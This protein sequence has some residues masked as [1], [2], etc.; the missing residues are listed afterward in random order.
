[1]QDKGNFGH[2][3]DFVGRGVDSHAS[4][5][6]FSKRLLKLLISTQEVSVDD[7]NHVV[8]L[9]ERVLKRRTS[10]THSTFRSEPRYHLEQLRRIVP[11]KI[12]IFMM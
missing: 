2:L 7:L 4:L 12:K 11:V 8:V 6:L 5:D 9:T 10:Q 3:L 1:M